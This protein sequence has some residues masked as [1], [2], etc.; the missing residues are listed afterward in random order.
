MRGTVLQGVAQG[1]ALPTTCPLGPPQDPTSRA[2]RLS[3]GAGRESSRGHQLE[4]GEAVL[5]LFQCLVVK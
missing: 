5:S 1:G 2:G 3:G 4:P